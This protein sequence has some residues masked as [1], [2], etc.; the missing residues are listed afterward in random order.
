MTWSFS[1]KTWNI[2]LPTD[3]FSLICSP[4]SKIYDAGDP[5]GLHQIM[6]VGRQAVMQQ[7]VLETL[8]D[9]TDY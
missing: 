8:A 6:A 3:G 2:L 5:T 4:M 1:W 9:Y 7:T